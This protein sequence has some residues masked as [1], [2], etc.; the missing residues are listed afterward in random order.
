MRPLA[1][2][3]S[4]V[5]FDMALGLEPKH[6][7]KV[8]S[9]SVSPILFFSDGLQEIVHN[10][11]AFLSFGLYESSTNNFCIAPHLSI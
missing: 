9:A 4:G 8:I 5:F 7:I 2:K 10:L 6:E 11:F 1:L 3:R